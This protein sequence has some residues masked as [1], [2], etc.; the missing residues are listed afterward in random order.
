MRRGEVNAK[1]AVPFVGELSGTWLPDDSERQAA[2]ELYVELVTRVAVIALGPNDG[3]LREAVDSLHKLFGTTREVLRRHGPG[4]APRTE[5][6]RLSVAYMAVAVLNGWLRPFL[7]VWHPRLSSYE[8]ERPTGVSVESWE[9]A[10]EHGREMRHEIMV[11]QTG[12]RQYARQLELIADVIS[13]FPDEAPGI[14]R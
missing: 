14:P 6:Q 7:S 12:L 11:V 9:A 8:A 3:L 13:L 2:W 1:L 10:W 4:I 5:Q